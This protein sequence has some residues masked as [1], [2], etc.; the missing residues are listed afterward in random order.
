M[1]IEKGYIYMMC[2]ITKK[3]EDTHYIV[4]HVVQLK[5]VCALLLKYSYS[6]VG[7]EVICFIV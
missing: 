7:D 6:I 3:A 2:V 4:C 1:V 5:F